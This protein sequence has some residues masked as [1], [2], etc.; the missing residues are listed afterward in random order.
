[1]RGKQITSLGRS[2]QITNILCNTSRYMD[3]IIREVTEVELQPNNRKG[4]D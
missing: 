4:D 3:C 2:P 1:V